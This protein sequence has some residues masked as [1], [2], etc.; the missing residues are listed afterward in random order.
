MILGMKALTNW[1]MAMML[2]VKGPSV[3][4]LLVCDESMIVTNKAVDDGQ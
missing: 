4:V 3:G 1:K 2:V